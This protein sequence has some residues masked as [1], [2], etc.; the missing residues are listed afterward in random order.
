M[1]EQPTIVLSQ[2]TKLSIEQCHCCD[3]IVIIY[4]NLLL[5]FSPGGFLK[6]ENS[7]QKLNF[8]NR[9]ITSGNGTQRSVHHA[10]GE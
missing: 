10:G 7:F 6:F 2:K 4:K 8:D 1:D 9:S 3:N 5:K